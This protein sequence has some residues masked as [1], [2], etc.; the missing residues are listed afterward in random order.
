MSGTPKLVC[1]GGK[2]YEAVEQVPGP[3]TR[4]HS[5]KKGATG[6]ASTRI[7]LLARILVE[8]RL[9]SNQSK[10]EE[11]QNTIACTMEGSCTTG[12]CTQ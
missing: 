3:R 2:E 5:S 4:C 7:A 8:C 6:P 12:S 11:V 9:K 10:S 1:F